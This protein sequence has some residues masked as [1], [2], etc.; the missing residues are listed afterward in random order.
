LEGVLEG[1]GK[2][3]EETW[4]SIVAAKGSVQHL[5]FL[6]DYEKDVFKTAFDIDQRW[7]VEHA[8]DRQKYICQGQ[9]VNLF[10]GA[11]ADKAYVNA[12]HFQAWSKGL[13]GLYY[14][15]T[16]GEKAAE[17]VS[18]KVERKALKDYEEC[19]ACQG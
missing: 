10:F 8:A 12:V 1:L 6:N 15:R 16:E 9:S 17:S 14:L 7:V 18:T 13:K 2:N 3:D 5:P 11:G 4:N 19:I